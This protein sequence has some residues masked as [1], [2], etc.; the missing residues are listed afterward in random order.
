MTFPTFRRVALAVGAA[1]LLGQAAWMVAATAS[2]DPLFSR[3]YGITQIGV[4]TAWT[5]SKGAGIKIAVIDS[6]VDVDHPDLKAKIDPASRDFAD[7]DNNADDDSPLK[8]GQ[9]QDLKG[10]GTHVAGIAAA[11]T[12]NGVGVAGTAPASSILALKAFS[13]RSTG[14]IL[15]ALTVVPNAIRYATDQGAKVINLS[16]GTFNGLPLVGIIESPCTEAYS[17]GALCVVASGNDGQANSSGYPSDFK[18]LVVTANDDKG[19]HADFG[20][21]PGTAWGVSAPGVN[22]TSTWPIDDTSHDGY[23]AIQG[24]SM[25]A[26]HAAGAAAL[27]FASGLTNAQVVQRLIDTASPPR[28]AALEGAGIINVARALGLSPPAVTTTTRRTA[29]TCASGGGSASGGGGAPAPAGGAGLAIPVPTTIDVNAIDPNAD[30]DFDSDLIGGGNEQ[31]YRPEL[32]D[33]NNVN[34]APAA[35]ITSGAVL[36]LGLF[37]GVT[38]QLRGRRGDPPLSSV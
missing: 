29:T 13:S 8:D 26:P 18:A 11:I 32:D 1:V 10:H 35:V 20:Q 36:L 5:K 17:R 2:N 25:A 14:S 33:K 28:N 9:G 21:R 38:V 3:Q 4:P 6:G 37:W 31:A 22:V 15:G 7:N 24:T 16:L 23:N 34:L 12:D 19:N 27:L 30:G